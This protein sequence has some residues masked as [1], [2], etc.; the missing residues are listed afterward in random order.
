MALGGTSLSDVCSP[1][2]A[3][4]GLAAVAGR[5]GGLERY[6]RKGVL[7]TKRSA[8]CVVC[9]IASTARITAAAV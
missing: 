9:V 7:S 8:A 6:E 3:V 4:N 5:W 1:D 2:P